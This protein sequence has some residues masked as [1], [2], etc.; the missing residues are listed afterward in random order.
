MCD[1]GREGG[2]NR[3]FGAMAAPPRTDKELT[4]GIIVEI[5]ITVRRRHARRLEDRAIAQTGGH[6]MP[7]KIHNLSWRGF[8]VDVDLQ[9]RTFVGFNMST[10]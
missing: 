5:I 8:S 10:K 3:D 9:P 7:P 2:L 6:E 1:R 4:N